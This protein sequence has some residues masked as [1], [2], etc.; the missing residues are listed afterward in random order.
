[1]SLESKQI[2]LGEA[3]TPSTP[4]RQTR[5]SS[6]TMMRQVWPWAF[7]V[8]LLLFFSV[9]SKLANNVNFLSMRSVMGILVYA[10]QILLIA[11]GETLVM[12][13]AGID[14]SAGWVLGFSSVIAAQ[15]M[16]G[17]N[18]QGAGPVET[19][20]LGFLAGVLIT[21]APGLVNGIL[22]TRIKVP[23]FIATLGMGFLVE[24]ISLV[25]TAGQ[26]VTDQPAYLGALGNNSLLYIW[27]GHPISWLKMPDA[28]TAA[29]LPNVSPFLPGVVVVTILVTAIIWFILAKTQFGQH[30]YAI[31]GNYEAS[32]RA[33][34]QVKLTLVK[35]YILAAIL[36]GIGGVLWAARFT[37]GAYNAGEVT[38]FQSI[39]A[40]VIGG[41]SMF[42]GEGTIIGTI[43]GT[44][45]I[46]TIQY[47]LVLVGVLAFWQY[48]A[49]GI[50][51]I[52][53]VI[54]DQFGRTLG[55]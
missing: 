2:N 16:R 7:L 36:A 4:K 27:P 20:G 55:K 44:L 21:L 33:G 14:L 52:L 37:G 32:N 35:A 40:V 8:V 10:S 51:V 54:V 18:A 1:M 38:T 11:L 23:A 26:T 31:G 46:A 39:A 41:T 28:A 45:C 29:D 34:I 49:I 17:L 43:I 15:V 25:I 22:V 53:A 50:V 19:V 3:K 12:V 24:G 13:A 9:Y 47:G 48:V 30:L 42:G 5:A 6:F